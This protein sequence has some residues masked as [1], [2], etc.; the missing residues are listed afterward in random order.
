MIASDYDCF[1][2][3]AD[4][5]EKFPFIDESYRENI[6]VSLSCHRISYSFSMLI[7]ALE[8]LQK[9]ALTSSPPFTSHSNAQTPTRLVP[10][11]APTLA[12]ERNVFLIYY[13]KVNNYSIRLVD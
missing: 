7:H 9:K 8:K 13:M 4:L 11:P 3:P 1:R 12:L 2:D 6:S 5:A 10:D